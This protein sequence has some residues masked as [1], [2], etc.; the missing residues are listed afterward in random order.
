M[1]SGAYCSWDGPPASAVLRGGCRGAALRTGRPSDSHSPAG[2]R[3]G[4][5]LRERTRP[6]PLRAHQPAGCRSPTQDG[7]CCQTPAASSSEGMHWPT[8]PGDSDPAPWAGSPSA[9]CRR[10][11]ARP[12]RRVGRCQ[13]SGTGRAGGRQVAFPSRR[14]RCPDR[15]RV[16]PCPGSGAV[17]AP[18][19]GQHPRGVRAGRP[20]RVVSALRRAGVRHSD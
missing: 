2:Q 7:C 16:R 11:P 17:K 12:D 6:H 1:R 18:A 19:G 9:W 5:R 4:R 8:P 13:I 3:A 10:C 15:F 14:R 20:R